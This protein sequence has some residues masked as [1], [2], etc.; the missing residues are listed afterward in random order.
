[1]TSAALAVAIRTPPHRLTGM[2]AI[3]HR[4]LN[5]DGYGVLERHEASDSIHLNADL[6]KTQFEL[7]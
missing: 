5:V 1:M 2:L 3:V 7:D 6:L 4:I